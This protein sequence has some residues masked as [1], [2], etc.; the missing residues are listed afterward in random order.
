MLN[1]G[2]NLRQSLLIKNA[3]IATCFSRR[4]IYCANVCRI[5]K[6]PFVLKIEPF[7]AFLYKERP[8]PEDAALSFGVLLLSDF[9]EVGVRFIR[10]QRYASILLP[11]P[12]LP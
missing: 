2:A 5:S 10:Q 9:Y 7:F 11:L 6:T 12:V 4:T 3:S 8:H 1:I